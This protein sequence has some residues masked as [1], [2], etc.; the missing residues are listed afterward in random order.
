MNVPEG[1]AED[2]SGNT[3]FFEAL[4][5]IIR[6]LDS[7]GHLSLFSGTPFVTGGAAAQVGKT[8]ASVLLNGDSYNSGYQFPMVYDDANARLIVGE[9]SS[10]DILYLPI[11]ASQTVSM[12]T[13]SNSLPA[14]TITSSD[15]SHLSESSDKNA[16]PIFDLHLN[17]S[18]LIAERILT[19]VPFRTQI[20]SYSGGVAAP[21]LGN[22]WTPFSLNNTG[23]ATTYTGAPTSIALAYSQP[24]ALLNGVPYLSNNGGTLVSNGSA[25]SQLSGVTS[26]FT[27]FDMTTDAANNKF[28]I[29]VNGNTMR[30]LVLYPDGSVKSYDLCMPGSFP[31]AVFVKMSRDGNSL[32]ISDTKQRR[33]LRYY[34]RS[35][36]A[37]HL[38]QK[39]TSGTACVP[40]TL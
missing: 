20:I 13:P 37:I 21:F 27:A 32:L 38:F 6:K 10:G 7:A 2:A 28:M 34:L 8:S 22:E 1:I 5:S 33:V 19:V 23:A 15:L 29:G 36:N 9:G 18:Q 4:T 35:N 11:S 14:N 24:M 40:I 30:G 26:F 3:Y 39:P 12:L 25:V 17:G 31:S 16:W